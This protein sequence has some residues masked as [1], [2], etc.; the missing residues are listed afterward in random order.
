MRCPKILTEQ[1]CTDYKIILMD[2]G[3][4]KGVGDICNI[5]I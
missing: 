5:H 1:T 3:F 2:N 4:T